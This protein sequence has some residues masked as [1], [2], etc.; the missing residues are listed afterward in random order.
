MIKKKTFTINLKKKDLELLKKVRK[1]EWLRGDFWFWKLFW[2][3]W[4]LFS[5]KHEHSISVPDSTSLNHCL[6]TNYI[7]TTLQLLGYGPQDAGISLNRATFK[8]HF[9]NKCLELG[10]VI[11]MAM[12][13]CSVMNYS[14]LQAPSGPKV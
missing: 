6:Q 5:A 14:H 8:R 13:C 9:V 11:G 10:V 12:A 3:S 2:E 1:Q 7:G 4:E